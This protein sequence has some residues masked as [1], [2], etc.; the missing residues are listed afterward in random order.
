MLE[1]KA[2]ASSATYFCQNGFS[3]TGGLTPVIYLYNERFNCHETE[4]KER[5]DREE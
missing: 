2:L 1:Y 5:P 4:N 3:V